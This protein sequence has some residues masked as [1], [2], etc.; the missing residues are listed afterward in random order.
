MLIVGLLLTLGA[1]LL[2]GRHR[3]ALVWTVALGYLGLIVLLE[4]Q[5]LRGQSVVRPDSATIVAFTL[6]AL[7][8]LGAAAALVWHA[9]AQ[10]AS[11]AAAG[12]SEQRSSAGA[13]RAE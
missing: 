6:L 5:A 9:R 2:D 13:R 7:L 1:R 11:T 8:T 10:V 3:V 12:E 4:W